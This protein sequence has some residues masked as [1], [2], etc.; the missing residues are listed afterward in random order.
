MK[1]ISCK[2]ASLDPLCLKN[3]LTILFLLHNYENSITFQIHMDDIE[4]ADR[5]IQTFKVPVRDFH[6]YS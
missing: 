4:D 5:L 1:G 3:F 2:I 6:F